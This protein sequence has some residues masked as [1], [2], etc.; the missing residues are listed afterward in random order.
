M[1]Y[2]VSYIHVCDIEKKDDLLYLYKKY[3]IINLECF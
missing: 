1:G 2:R 3:Q